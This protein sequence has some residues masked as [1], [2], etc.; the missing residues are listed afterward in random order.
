MAE[1]GAIRPSRPLT[2]SSR[3]THISPTEWRWVVLVALGVLALTSLPYLVG[4]AASTPERL[5]GGFVFAV[6][7]G[8]SYLAKMRLGAR[9][10]WLFHDVYTAEP[11]EGGLFFPFHLLLGKLAALAGWSLILTYHL[12]RLAFGFILL[13]VTYRFIAAFASL[14]RVR[15]LAFLLVALSGGLGWLLVALGA[16]N[17][18]NSPPLDV[19]LPEGYTFLAVFGFPHLAAARSLLL[20]GLL[21][22]LR[23]FERGQARFAL[24]AGVAWLAMGLIVPF[25]VVIAG[26]VVITYLIARR[27]PPPPSPQA[28]GEGW[29]NRGGVRASWLL[30]ALAGLV[31]APIVLY[32]LIAFSTNPVFRAWS[33]Q[34]LIL[35]PH[36]LH[37]V[38]GYLVPGLLAVPGARM[39]WRKVGHGRLLV[40]WVVIAPLLVYIPFNLQ[41]R[42]IEGFQVPLSLLAAYGFYFGLAPVLR[43]RTEDGGRRI[44]GGVSSVFRPPPAVAQAAL[45]LFSVLTPLMLAFGGTMAALARSEPIFHSASEVAALDWLDAHAPPDALVLSAYETGNYLPTRADVRAFLGLGPET[46]DLPRKR[47]LVA[48]FYR[49]GKPDVLWAYGVHYVIAGPRERALGSFDLDAAPFLERVYTNDDYTIYR[50]VAD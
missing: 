37:Y 50:V 7:D 9:G 49:S 27:L 40:A 18:L 48:E 1:A 21:F 3:A 14:R 33:Q 42:L 46:V 38:L 12:A 20:G 30:A 26:V 11:H 36:P 32:S 43:R 15:R 47:A 29:G 44:K 16:T 41:R 24:A 39:A 5:F 4:W 17:W 45:L 28:R 25:Y 23:A 2:L 13:L 34:N 8:H 10:D 19:Y 31:A 35:S 22:L 6:E